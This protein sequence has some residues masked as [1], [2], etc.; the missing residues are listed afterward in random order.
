MGYVERGDLTEEELDA[1]LDVRTMTGPG[2]EPGPLARTVC[3][4][5]AGTTTSQSP[6]GGTS[7]PIPSS[8][9]SVAPRISGGERLAVRRAGT[10]GRR[11]RAAPASGRRSR[12]SC[13]ACRP[14]SATD[15]EPVVGHAGLRGRACG[16]RRRRATA[17]TRSSSSHRAPAYSR[18]A[19]TISSHGAPRRPS[20]R[21]RSRPARRSPRPVAP[22]AGA[23]CA[24]ARSKAAVVAISV[25]LRTRSGC[26][27]ARSC[28]IP[29][30]ME[31]PT[32][33][34]PGR[35]ARRGRA[36]GRPRGRHRCTTAPRPASSWTARCRGCRSGSRTVRRRRGA[37]RTPAPTSPSTRSRRR[38]AGRQGHG[39]RVVTPRRS[40]RPCDRHTTMSPPR[41]LDAPTRHARGPPTR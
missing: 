40:T 19:S 32:R 22:V 17:R 33:W 28:A 16:R 35:R 9:S 5:I 27:T 2:A 12:P 37:R 1:A 31:T 14:S 20:R 15:H 4:T 38:R 18:C 11:C 8:G 24:S 39:P 41:G 6:W 7:W 29:P 13:A 25:R 23:A 36:A 26:W 10:A 21:R 34:A 3:S 30:P